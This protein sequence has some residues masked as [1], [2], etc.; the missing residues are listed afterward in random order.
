[1]EHGG[2][3]VGNFDVS[4]LER[5]F[6]ARMETGDEVWNSPEERSWGL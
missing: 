4:K 3:G 1:M 6:N 5:K 2:K